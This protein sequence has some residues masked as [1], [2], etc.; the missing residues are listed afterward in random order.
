MN[1]EQRRTLQRMG[2]AVVVASKLC[3][4]CHSPWCPVCEM[5]ADWCDS[6]GQFHCPTCEAYVVAPVPVVG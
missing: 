3:D 1:R 5:H 6:C 2:F 4:D